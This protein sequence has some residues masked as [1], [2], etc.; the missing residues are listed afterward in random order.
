MKSFL[1]R[2]HITDQSRLVIA[3]SGGADSMYLLCEMLASHAVE[4]II[5][6]HF[7]HELRAAESDRDEAFV[8]DFCTK[9]NLLFER[10]S[11]DI[12]SLAKV[13]KL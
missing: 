12:S 5:V 13:Q 9:N 7:N 2:H 10:G 4:G 8:R 1:D 3:C 6:A 11:A